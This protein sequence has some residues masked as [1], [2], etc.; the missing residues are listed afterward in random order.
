[1][2]SLRFPSPYNAREKRARFYEIRGQWVPLP[3]M[4]YI[5]LWR[6]FIH[7]RHD[8][9]IATA[10]CARAPQRYFEL[11]GILAGRTRVNA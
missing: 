1:M 4:Q 3:I 10:L 2:C 9:V 7:I 6:Q 11:D 5:R 8:G